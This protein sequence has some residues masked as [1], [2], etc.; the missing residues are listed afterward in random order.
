[1][2]APLDPRSPLV[3][4]THELSRRPGSMRRASLTVP[5]PPRLGIDVLGV[6][7][8]TDLS[9]D[10]RLESVVEGVLVTGSA[11]APVEGECVRCLEQLDQ[12]LT[13]EFQELFLY[14]GADRAPDDE[15]ELFEL[16]GD[17]LDLEPVIRNAVVLA[18]PLQP[19]C[20][21][22]CPGLCADC[23]VRMADDPTHQHETVDTRWQAL[24]GLLDGDGRSGVSSRP[25]MSDTPAHHTSQER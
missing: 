18:L 6:R 2:T 15:D 8:G 17:L 23:G 1:M 24:V 25:Q 3:L 7:E 4:D 5:A 11:S 21:E 10:L 22:S 12:T 13:V 14:D 20:D 19:V 16:N 9:L